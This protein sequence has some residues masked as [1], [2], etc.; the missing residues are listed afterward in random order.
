MARRARV[1]STP[2]QAGEAERDWTNHDDLLLTG[3]CQQHGL[4]VSRGIA[5]NGAE[6]VACNRRRH[7]LRERLSNSLVWDGVARLD[8]WLTVYMG[9]EDRPY[10]R[11]VGRKWMISGVARVNEPG[12]QVRTAS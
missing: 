7:P 1:C 2:W 5:T 3:W 9:A 8:K 10:T 12:C 11:A 4:N 6:M